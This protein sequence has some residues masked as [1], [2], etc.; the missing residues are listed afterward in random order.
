MLQY[1][2]LV[3]G[4]TSTSSCQF[5]KQGCIC[6]KIRVYVYKK[7]DVQRMTLK[8]H[9]HAKKDAKSL[10]Y[11]I[12][13]FISSI[14]IYLVVVNI[15]NI[16]IYALFIAFII[17]KSSLD[18]K[19]SDSTIVRVIQ[20]YDIIFSTFAI[21]IFFIQLDDLLNMTRYTFNNAEFAFVLAA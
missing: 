13:K 2:K 3:A 7:Y 9:A 1:C 8:V 15:K 11:L 14:F 17:T 21:L 4:I 6:I 18:S 5:D 19:I 12:K 10:N 16:V 20:T